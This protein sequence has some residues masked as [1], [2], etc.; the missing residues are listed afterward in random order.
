VRLPD[1]LE[2]SLLA[3]GQATAGLL[4]TLEIC[5]TRR[6][7]HSVWCQPSNGDGRVSVS[8]SYL[9]AECDK[10]MNLFLMDYGHPEG[11]FARRIVGRIA[12]L[13]DVKRALS[14][15]K[16][17]KGIYPFRDNYLTDL[18]HAATILKRLRRATLQPV[19]VRKQSQD[20]FT[21]VL[22]LVVNA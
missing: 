22:D 3:N 1:L 10:D 16:R 19:L 5:V 21:L 14:G 11:D 2:V 4:L 20:D 12:T 9:L 8:R 15:Y 6:G 13:A 18:Q 7:N 17:Y